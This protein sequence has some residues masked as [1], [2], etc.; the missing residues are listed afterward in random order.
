MLKKIVSSIIITAL[1]LSQLPCLAS[2]A[3]TIEKKAVVADPVNQVIILSGNINNGGDRPIFIKV[4]AQDGTLAWV[5]SATSNSDGDFGVTIGTSNLSGSEYKV[6]ASYRDGA[7]VE[8]YTYAGMGSVTPEPI[9]ASVTSGDVFMK[10]ETAVDS[11]FN[12]A[13]LKLQN[14]KVM[15]GTATQ[16]SYEITGLPV[17]ISAT[18]TATSD[19]TLS[20]AFAGTAL[21]AVTS[22]C[23][24]TLKLKSNM[25]F[26]GSANTDSAVITGIRIMP[27]TDV[28]KVLFDKT[29]ANLS[30][31]SYKTP[32]ESPTEL[33]LK[34][35][36][37]MVNGVL[38]KGTDFDYTLPSAMSGLTVVASANKTKGTILLTL[39]G[40]AR[41]NVT[42]DIVISDFVFKKEIAKNAVFDS[43]ALT[44]TIKKASE[45]GGYVG[46]GG[47]GGGAPSIIIPVVD[48]K[49]EPIVPIVPSV[50][51]DI[52]THWA[53]DYI[54]KLN[55]LGYVKGYEDNTYRPD[56]KIT[57]AELITLI[58]R[59]MGVEVKRYKGSYSDVTTDDWFCDYIQ[60]ALDLGI[61]SEDTNFRPNDEIKR[62][63][64]VKI[65]VGAY[66]LENEAPTLN[67]SMSSINDSSQISERAKE[68][69]QIALNLGL[70]S[71]YDDGNFHAS[72]GATRGECA[73]ILARLI[74]CMSK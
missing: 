29:T 19:D 64:L 31:Q 61:I 2:A 70:V 14:S 73:A 59:I 21:S 4:K 49:V 1:M 58:M 25:I 43:D 56:N 17:G 20:I 36:D 46:G 47:G 71:G 54:D 44:L 68:F 32:S 39:T 12:K 69:V 48:T 74:D 30:M 16:S 51:N 23:A 26:G 13:T 66:L 37:L 45:E 5:G 53:K 52:Q 24:L 34:Y 40:E 72:N 41:D 9:S 10:T 62:D 57:R 3:V 18:V 27:Y 28:Q 35:R 8:L 7:D 15:L 67:I 55:K 6:Y 22:E 50:I 33:T 38:T 11:D 42:S 63:E 60:T 65:A